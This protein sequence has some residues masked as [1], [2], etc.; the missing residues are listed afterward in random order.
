MTRM[1]YNWIMRRKLDHRENSNRG[2]NNFT[3]RIK[4]THVFVGNFTFITDF[5]IVEDISSIIDPRLSQV[6]LGRPFIE[7]SNMTHDPPEGVVRFTNRN[8]E[9]DKRRGVEYVMSKIL[10]FYKECL[11]LGPEYLTGMDDEEEVTK[12][13][14]YQAVPL[15]HTSYICNDPFKYNYQKGWE[16]AKFLLSETVRYT[17]FR[18]RIRSSSQTRKRDIDLKEKA[19]VDTPNPVIFKPAQRTTWKRKTTKD[20]VTMKEYY[21]YIIQYRKDQGITLLKRGKLFQYLY[22]NVCVAITRADTNAAGLGKRIVLPHTFTSGPRYMMQNYQDAMALCRAYGNPDL[23]ITFTS[24]PNAR[25]HPSYVRYRNSKKKASPAHI[26]LY[27]S[28]NTLNARPTVDVD[29]RFQ[30]RCPSP[31]DNSAGYKGFLDPLEEG[32]R[33]QRCTCKWC[34]LVLENDLV[35]FSLQ[36]M[37]IHPLMLLTL[38]VIFQ[39]FS[40]TLHNPSTRHTRASYVEMILTMVMIVHHGSR[41]FNQPPQYS[42]DHQPQIIQEDQ[43]WISK[44]NNNFIESVRSMFEEFRERLQA[45]NI[46]T[47]TPEPSRRFN[48]FYD[49][50]DYKESTIPLTEIVSQIPP[51]IAITPVLP[52]LEP[53]DSLIMGNEELS[54]I[55]EKESDE[56]IKSSVEDLVPIPSKSE[57]TFG[58]DSK[59]DLP[60]CNDFSPIKVFEEKSV[61]FS[62]PLFDSNEDFTSSDD[63]SLSDEDVPEDNVKIYSNPLFEFDDEY[64][65]GDVNPLFDEVLENIESK[66]S[67]VSNLDKPAL[68]VTPLSDANEDECFDPGGEID[69]IDAFLDIDVSTDIENGYHDSEGDI[70]YLESLLI[71][72]TIPNLP[73]EVFLDRDPRNLEDEP[74]KDDLMTKNKVFDLGIREKIF[75]PTYVSLPFEDRY[76]L[77]L[78]HVIR[79]FLPYFTYPVESFSFLL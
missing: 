75:S 50:D 16:C 7:I 43:E 24:N 33:C 61:T 29:D 31:K 57:D 77:S 67:Y 23:F 62:N 5:M 40:P 15:Q 32:E 52:T 8:D 63:E 53:E 39:T 69:E 70:I 49:D 79:I 13:P 58:S 71:N 36:E 6:V 1:M 66:D 73:P 51:S 46:S 48:S 44:L 3:G 74:D 65:S 10:G 38:S 22:L 55:L 56:V 18:H 68:L 21:A 4:G 59:C 60:S 14:C 45:A 17:H 72:N 12:Q 9:E 30:P 19:I 42:I 78:T 11:E 37:K 2:I 64:I 34:G 25:I 41:F 27:E 35:G 54:T 26:L 47:H 28:M 20:N 76:Y